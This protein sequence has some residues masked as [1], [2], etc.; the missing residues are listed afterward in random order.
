MIMQFIAVIL[1]RHYSAHH[2]AHTIPT[3]FNPE[4]R[5]DMGMDE[6]P[7]RSWT[8]NLRAGEAV[9]LWS[10]LPFTASPERSDGTSTHRSVPL[11]VPDTR[12]VPR[13]A[14]P[15]AFRLIPNA[16]SSEKQFGWMLQDALARWCHHTEPGD[17]RSIA[18]YPSVAM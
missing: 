15:R 17:R 9:K 14:E 13:D 6:K 11:A 8:A 7:R 16:I 3:W 5:F 10:S 12:V 4:I 18:L 2:P 1:L